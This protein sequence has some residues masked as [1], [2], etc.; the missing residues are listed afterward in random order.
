MGDH[1]ASIKIEMEFHGIK[2]T[3]DMWINYYPHD[4]CGMDERIISF[5]KDVYVRGILAYDE[6][7]YESTLKNR[8]IEIKDSE[9]KEL[10]RLKAKWEPHI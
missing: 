3:A 5:F 8:E 10:A 6:M 9:L 2:E 7:I 1:R 4:C